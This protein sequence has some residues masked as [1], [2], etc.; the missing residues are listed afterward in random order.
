MALYRMYFEEEAH[1]SSHETLVRGL[2][3]AG[4]E[5][6]EAERVVSEE[7]LWEG[8]TKR[9]V[10]EQVGNGVDSVPVVSVEGRRRDLEFVG[11]REVE[12]Y[13]K[14]LETVI[15]ESQ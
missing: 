10:Q 4:V 11:A 3:E 13:V 5:K 2:V 15:K 12:G 8:E 1:P 6:G 9:A 14:G 7:G